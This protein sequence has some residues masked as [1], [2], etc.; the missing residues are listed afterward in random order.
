MDLAFNSDI[1]FCGSLFCRLVAWSSGIGEALLT[2][3]HVQWICIGLN[4]N[5]MPGSSSLLSHVPSCQVHSHCLWLQSSFPTGFLQIPLSVVRYTSIRNQ[6]GC[7][8]LVSWQ[9]VMTVHDGMRPCQEAL[10]IC[11]RVSEFLPRFLFYETEFAT[12]HET[13]SVNCRD[14][15]RP[16]MCIVWGWPCC[17]WCRVTMGMRTPFQCWHFTKVAQL[18]PVIAVI[19][20]GPS[21]LWLLLQLQLEQLMVTN[22]WKNRV[23]QLSGVLRDHSPSPALL[24]LC[25]VASGSWGMVLLCGLSSPHC[26]TSGHTN[27][28]QLRNATSSSNHLIHCP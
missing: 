18:F 23:Q 25:N 11:T 2:F 16:K 4:P 6:G 19:W 13:P 10:Q 22:V 21:S 24:M 27:L 5:V 20:Y 26:S 15:R 7:R 28:L 8:I 17:S 1:S 3:F 14:Y 12:G 9:C